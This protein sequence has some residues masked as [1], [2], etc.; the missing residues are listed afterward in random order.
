MASAHELRTATLGRMTESI[1]KELNE[2]L[3]AIVINSSTCLRMLSADPP[4]VEGARETARRTISCSDRAAKAVS[5]L[6]AL[7]S[8]KSKRIE[9]VAPSKG[10]SSRVAPGG[11]L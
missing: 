6:H 11:T 4:N 3:C 1:A 8:E 7:F 5:H 2:R 10:G 9:T